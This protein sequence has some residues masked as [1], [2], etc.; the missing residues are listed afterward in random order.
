MCFLP[1]ILLL[2]VPAAAVAVGVV[3]YACVRRTWILSLAE[4]EIVYGEAR[5][6]AGRTKQIIFHKG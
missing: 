3:L 6:F 4:R 5:R 1:F 2:P